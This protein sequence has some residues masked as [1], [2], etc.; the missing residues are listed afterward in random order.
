M[1]NKTHFYQDSL[2][3]RNGRSVTFILPVLPY[4]DFPHVDIMFV[5]EKVKHFS[6]LNNILS[7]LTW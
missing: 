6:N 1:K 2:E 4:N 3:C 7:G 5:P